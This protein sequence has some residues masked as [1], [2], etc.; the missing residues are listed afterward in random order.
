MEQKRTGGTET[1]ADEKGSKGLG[2][3]AALG[4]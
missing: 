2:K 1:G 4:D 3:K